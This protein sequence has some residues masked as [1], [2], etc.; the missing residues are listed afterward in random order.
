MRRCFPESPGTSLQLAWSKN[1]RGS[2]AL[3]RLGV[4]DLSNRK[5]K[6]FFFL[7]KTVTANSEGLLSVSSEIDLILEVYCCQRKNSF[8]LFSLC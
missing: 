6:I 2:V 5:L 4:Y 3:L 7:S 8:R 1:D